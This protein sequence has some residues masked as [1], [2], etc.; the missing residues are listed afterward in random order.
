MNVIE[1]S[2]AS[3]QEWS[4]QNKR[5]VVK[6]EQLNVRWLYDSRTYSISYIAWAIAPPHLAYNVNYGDL[7]EINR[8]RHTSLP[9]AVHESDKHV[10]V[11]AILYE[12][13]S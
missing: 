8:C 10:A 9:V 3:K 4:N 12:N 13:E 2:R 11:K 6:I 1:Q 7:K 5:T